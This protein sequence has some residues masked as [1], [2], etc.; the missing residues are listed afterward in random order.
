M[1]KLISIFAIVLFFAGCSL[2]TYSV[3]IPVAKLQK[4]ME[5]KFPIKR[6][7]AIGTLDLAQPKVILNEKTKRVI[8][9]MSFGY[10]MPLFSTQTGIISVS[11]IPKYRANKSAFYLTKP[12]IEELKFN[13]NSMGNMLSK[14]TKGLFSKIVEEIFDKYPIYKIK[15]GSTKNKLLK[16]TIKSINVKHDVLELNLGI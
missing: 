12:N 10:K 3:K 11:G 7:L 13:N 2:S 16:N 5:K 15:D 14:N 1:K 9:K 4:G 8:T 6:K